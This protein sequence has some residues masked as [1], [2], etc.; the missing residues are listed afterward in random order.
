MIA[1]RIK[2]CIP[3][4]HKQIMC[5]DSVI[6]KYLKADLIIL[7]PYPVRNFNVFLINPAGITGK[8]N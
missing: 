3:N 2:A 6:Y 8:Q 7:I 4:I 1:E 5:T